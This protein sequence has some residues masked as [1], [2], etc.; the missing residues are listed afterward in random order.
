MKKLDMGDSHLLID[1]IAKEIPNAKKLPL[2]IV[3]VGVHRGDLSRQ[4]LTKLP[5]S[6]LWMVDNWTVYHDQH[7]YR[8]SNDGCAALT[9]EEQEENRHAACEVAVEFS[10][11]DWS[12]SHRTRILSQGSIEAAM[13]AFSERK[14][15]HA[16]IID[17]SHLYEDVVIDLAIWFPL[18]RSGGVFA[19]H[20]I[21]HPKDKRGV[22]GVRRA[23]ERFCRDNQLTFKTM[24]TCWWIVKP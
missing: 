20:D 18:V 4:I 7:S 8:L 11:V 12:T 2:E 6:C 21:D 17:A 13:V 24:G 15:F 9:R 10:G 16:A 3:E 1:I 5:K 19:G 14:S 22:W 23:V